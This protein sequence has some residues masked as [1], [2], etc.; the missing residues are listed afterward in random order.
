MSAI[1]LPCQHGNLGKCGRC[2]TCGGPLWDLPSMRRKCRALHQMCPGIDVLEL[3][4]GL[5]VSDVREFV[6]EG[7]E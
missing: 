5:E 3:P 7:L 4:E 2:L 6:G 1:H